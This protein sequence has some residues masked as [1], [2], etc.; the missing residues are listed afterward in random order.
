M[1][2]LLEEYFDR[3]WPLHRS[4][5]GKGYRQSLN[6]ISELVPFTR[7][8]FSTGAECHDWIIP[9]E[10]NFNRAY[11]K[12]PDGYLFC[13]TQVNNLHVVGYSTPYAGYLTWGE[14]KEHLQTVPELPEAIPYVTSYY[15]PRWGFCL[16]RREFDELDSEYKDSDL[17]YVHIDSSLE[18]GHVVVGSTS[19]H[20]TSADEILLSSYLCHPSLA[21]NELSGPLVLAGAYQKLKL[22]NLNKTVRFYI[23]PENIGVV[24]YLSILGQHFLKHLKAGWVVNSV[25]IPP[26]YTYKESRQGNSLADRVAKNV[27]G[28][29]VY[30]KQTQYFPDGSDE[31]M[32][33]SP[34]YNL[35]VGVFMRTPWWGYKEYHTSLDN[36]ALIDFEVL[37]ESVD[38]V[39]DMVLTADRNKTYKSTIQYGTPMFA[40]CKEDIYAS[41]MKLNT[42]NKGENYRQ[43]LLEIVNWSDGEH[44]LLSIAE[45]YD[46][47]ML[48]IVPIADM[49]ER[50]GYIREV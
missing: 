46:R 49:L 47:K 29:L 43:P 11:I 38:A 28:G 41:T 48:D 2:H 10:W 8:N 20:G 24:A 9:K 12:G 19:L 31:R 42:Y 27:L 39:V 33:C 45:K 17:C 13:D 21:N 23:G 1:K 40:K 3:L 15:K 26:W 44:D 25:G 4:I 37:E 6:I 7:I 14:L 30:Y 50:L 32:Y 18:D 34:G 16:T 5:T 36:K 22:L 35:P